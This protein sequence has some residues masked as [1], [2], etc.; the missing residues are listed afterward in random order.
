MGKIVDGA[1]IQG[2]RGNTD[3]AALVGARIYLASPQGDKSYPF[4]SVFTVAETSGGGVM[5][6]GNRV[7]SRETLLQIDV[8][9]TEISGYESTRKIADAVIEACDGQKL[10]GDFTDVKIFGVKNPSLVFVRYEGE[11]WHAVIQIT[12]M[13]I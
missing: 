11:Y 10:A 8:W 7:S 2:L 4:C 6:V 13:W 3:L 9:E 1:I 12:V 5:P